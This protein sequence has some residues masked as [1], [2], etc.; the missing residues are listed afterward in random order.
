[1]ANK[2]IIRRKN[3]PLNIFAEGGPVGNITSVA[4]IKNPSSVTK[5]GQ[6]GISGSVGMQPTGGSGGFD[7]GSIGG[8]GSSIGTIV[9]AGIDNARL[10]DTSSLDDRIK[11]QNG[12]TVGARSN[13]ELINEWGSWV[14]LKDNYNWK[15]VRGGNN[16]QRALNTV[17]ATA[18]GAATG[19]S[20]GGP[21][22]AIVGG[23]VGLGS[24][25]AGWFTGNRKAKKK[26]KRL[27][28]Q[29]R[30]ANERSISSFELRAENIDTQND[31]T[32]LDN[33]SAYGGFIPTG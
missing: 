3:R 12:M 24:S 22:G 4:D 28:Q 33:Y 10:A 31:F 7:M 27:N 14:G 19:A 21:V 8:I 1:M 9:N 18:S 26:A 25:L 23:V 2:R 20:V 16:G 15:D 32:Q 6:G 13:D 11:A 17:S 5:L 30:D 29:A